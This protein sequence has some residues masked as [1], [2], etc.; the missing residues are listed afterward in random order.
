MN[1]GAALHQH[2]QGHK[3]RVEEKPGGGGGRGGGIA[4][5]L[6]LGAVCCNPDQTCFG[7]TGVGCLH[8]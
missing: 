7:T 2:Q 4:S 1:V 6:P 8:E 5:G 3:T